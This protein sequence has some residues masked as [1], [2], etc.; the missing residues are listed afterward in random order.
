M[1]IQTGVKKEDHHMEGMHIISALLMNVM[2][3]WKHSMAQSNKYHAIETILHDFVKMR[4]CLTS[5][6]A[7]WNFIK[8]H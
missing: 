8:L 7:S 4:S 5:E 2:I 6:W 1:T 3:Y